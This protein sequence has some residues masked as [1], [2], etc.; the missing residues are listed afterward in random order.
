MR[1]DLQRILKMDASGLGI[2]ETNG[3]EESIN[4]RELDLSNNAIAD[5]WQVGD[6]RELR[7]LDLSDNQIED[8]SYLSSLTKLVSLD[9]S[10][11][12][13]SDGPSQSADSGQ[14]Q[15]ASFSLLESTGVLGYL[16]G[17]ESLEILKFA[18]N[19]ISDLD[20][21]NSLPALEELDLSGNS[22]VDLTPLAQLPNLE[23]VSIFDNP[24]DLSEGS[25]QSTVLENIVA[26]TG[27]NILV[28][29]PDPNAPL[30]S[31][32][33]DAGNQQFQ[34]Q[35]DVGELQTSTDLNIWTDIGS[36]QSPFT[37]VPSDG[38]V[39]WRLEL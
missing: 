37:V 19:N 23:K 34:L 22:V 4:M 2:V 12:L 20:V 14:V 11:N 21:L 18:N 16:N 1:L 10:G 24:V 7:I 38:P 36:A 3:F 8:I 13:L 25:S 32:D 33:W 6:M 30:L 26:S 29:A 9:L 28:E 31:V 15:M 17:I 27:A 5:L 39:F 35:W